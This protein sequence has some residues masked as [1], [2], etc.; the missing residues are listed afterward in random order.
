MPPTPTST[1][2][3]PARA[4][5]ERAERKPLATADTPGLPHLAQEEETLPH[6]AEHPG[7]VRPLSVLRPALEHP[8]DVAQGRIHSGASYPRTGGR[9]S[10]RGSLRTLPALPFR[11]PPRHGASDVEPL[12]HRRQGRSEERRVGKECRSRWSPYH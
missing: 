6:G 1:K 12:L 8:G 7:L 10:G 3:T 2:S 9:G 11:A 5:A 4:S